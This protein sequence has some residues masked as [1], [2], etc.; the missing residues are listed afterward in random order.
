MHAPGPLHP[1]R[2]QAHLGVQWATLYGLPRMV[3]VA[4]RIVG[5][6]WF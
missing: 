2:A 5:G 4:L 3:L 1:A 6:S